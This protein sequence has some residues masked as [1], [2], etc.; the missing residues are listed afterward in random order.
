MVVNSA[1]FPYGFYKEIV[2]PDFFGY[3]TSDADLVRGGAGTIKLSLHGD[4][5]VETFSDIPN[6]VGDNIEDGNQDGVSYR[7]KDLRPGTYRLT[8]NAAGSAQDSDQPIYLCVD[9]TCR[10]FSKN[11]QQYEFNAVDPKALYLKSKA[12]VAYLVLKSVE[13]KR[14]D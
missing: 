11:Q 5:G 4:S 14:E 8:V 1:L 10:N 3:L 2:R 7:L 6:Y 9:N 13:W 12:D